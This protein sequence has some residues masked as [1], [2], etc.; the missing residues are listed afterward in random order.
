MLNFFCIA[1]CMSYFFYP[2]L[3][4][5][6]TKIKN[7]YEVKNKA[8]VRSE[9]TLKISRFSKDSFYIS[10]S[11]DSKQE[12]KYSFFDGSFK[13]ESEQS[14]QS[15]N[16][17]NCKTATII[18]NGNRVAIDQD[19]VSIYLEKV[20]LFSYIKNSGCLKLPLELKKIDQKIIPSNASIIT[21]HNVKLTLKDSNQYT[22]DRL[23]QNEIG[24][25]E[26]FNNNALKTMKI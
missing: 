17:L 22:I 3:G 6:I 5:L 23:D 7:Y 9:N 21:M 19:T 25:I 11:L 13:M 20:F 1:L 15:I 10:Y 8:A 24:L 14:V 18:Q 16:C 26:F 4:G 2:V 12:S